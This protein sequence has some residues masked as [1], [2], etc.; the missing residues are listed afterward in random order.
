[1]RMAEEGHSTAAA[2]NL[3]RRRRAAKE[4]STNPAQDFVNLFNCCGVD[5]GLGGGNREGYFDI[6]RELETARYNETK[7]EKAQREEMLRQKYRRK[8]PSDNLIEN[9]EVVQ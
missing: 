5:L 9:V 1:M 3:S 4:A 7:K 2:R 6:T 8:P